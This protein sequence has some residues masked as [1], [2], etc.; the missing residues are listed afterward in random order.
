MR[1]YTRL[2]SITVHPPEVPLA[3]SS[4]PSSNSDDEVEWLLGRSG[5]VGDLFF[6]IVVAGVSKSVAG[7]GGGG[8]RRM[9]AGE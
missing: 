2:A 6:N 5:T 1:F 4:S 7:A 9:T 3:G 8:L